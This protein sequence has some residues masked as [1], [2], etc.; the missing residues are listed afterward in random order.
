MMIST[1]GRYALRVMID[2]AEHTKDGYT[3]M[4]DVAERQRLSLKYLERIL[5]VLSKNGLVEGV[6]GKGGGYKLT[7][8]PEEYRCLFFYL[9]SP[10]NSQGISPE[11]HPAMLRRR[12]WG[13]AG[14]K[15]WCDPSA[16]GSPC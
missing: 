4:K 3:P 9:F 2:L 7:R 1:R 8:S 14:C 12:R 5:P 11:Y 10:G 6:H 16:P 15:L 13:W